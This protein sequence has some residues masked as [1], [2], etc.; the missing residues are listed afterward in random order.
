M[1]EACQET[2]EEHHIYMLRII[3]KDIDY[4]N[5]I[6]ENLNERIKQR[7]IFTGNRCLRITI[8]PSMKLI[9][10]AKQSVL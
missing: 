7:S 9:S 1:Y 5:L 6:I 4:T 2:I 8:K 3:Q 10:T